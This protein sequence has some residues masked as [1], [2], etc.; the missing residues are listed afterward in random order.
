MSKELLQHCVELLAPMGH[1]RS[2]RMFGG[3]G[4]YLDDLFVA[5]IAF[6]QLYLKSDAATHAQ[7]EA[8]GSQPFQYERKGQTVAA[9]G[10][11]CAPEEAMESSALMRPWAQLALGAALRA[12]S[13]KAAKAAKASRPVKPAARPRRKT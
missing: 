6:D 10:Y 2:R 8:A 3:W 5:L 4:L 7:F 9:L 13:A 1:V 11:F 12:N